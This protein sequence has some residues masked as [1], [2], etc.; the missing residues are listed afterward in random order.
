MAGAA[1]LAGLGTGLLTSAEDARAWRGEVIRHE[2]DL[3]AH[4]VQRDLLEL[5]RSAYR[6][7][8]D[9]FVG[10]GELRTRG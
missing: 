9:V 5:R 4:R 8:R 2:P 3:A 10:L 6:G 1:I 7:L